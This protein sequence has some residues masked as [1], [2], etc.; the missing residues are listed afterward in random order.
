MKLKR[1][2]IVIENYLNIPKNISGVYIIFNTANEKYYIGSSH[3]IKRRLIR[4]FSDI[5]CERHHC[6]HLS[7]AVKKYGKEKFIIYI[8]ICKDYEKEENHLLSKEKQNEN[9]YNHLFVTRFPPINYQK[10]YQYDVNGKFI[11]EFNSIKLAGESVKIDSS[12]IC[13]SIRLGHLC[14]GFQWSRKKLECL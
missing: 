13:K 6:I 8:K 5:K 14:R 4:H 1:D 10:I 7:R 9:C 11:K 3:D 12:N 2:Y